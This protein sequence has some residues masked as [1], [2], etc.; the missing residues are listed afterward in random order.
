MHYFYLAVAITAEVTGTTAL[1][2][3]EGFT[4]LLPSVVVV[5]GYG[6]A[7]SRCGMIRRT[8]GWQQAAAGGE[9]R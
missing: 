8:V 1:K 3:T 6:S 5:V 9:V 7:F 2:S 4:S